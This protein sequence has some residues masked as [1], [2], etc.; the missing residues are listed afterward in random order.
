MPLVHVPLRNGSNWS[1]RADF[2]RRV[3]VHAP[4]RTDAARAGAAPAPSGPRLAPPAQCHLRG[5]AC[6]VSRGA[7]A[8]RRRARLPPLRPQPHQ[9]RREGGEACRAVVQPRRR[10]Q[11]S[12]YPPRGERVRISMGGVSAAVRLLRRRQHH[13]QGP[14]PPLSPGRGGGAAAACAPRHARH[15]R[16]LPAQGRAHPRPPAVPRLRRRPP[17]LGALLCGVAG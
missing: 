3:G 2:G 12:L 9:G 6:W 5:A 15:R 8:L 7:G 4:F 17:E 10:L 14:C 16:E 11:G 13:L 1:E